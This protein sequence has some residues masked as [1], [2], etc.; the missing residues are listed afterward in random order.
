MSASE[1]EESCLAVIVIYLDAREPA[2][3]LLERAVEAALLDGVLNDFWVK[4]DAGVTLPLDSEGVTRPECAGVVLPFDKEADGV[5]VAENDDGVILPVEFVVAGV[6]LPPL[7]DATEEGR[8]TAPGPTVGGDSFVTAT[9]TPH[10]SG[11]VKY[12]FLKRTG[13]QKDPCVRPRRWN[14]G[15][16]GDN[17]VGDSPS[18]RAIVFSFASKT[19]T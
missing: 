19:S 18:H 1:G 15:K 6:D 7:E 11:H 13:D 5:R 16:I 10:L 9:K 4:L 17:G 3:I 12:C 14:D 8:C 2:V